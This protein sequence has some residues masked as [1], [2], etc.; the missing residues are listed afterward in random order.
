SKQSS[1]SGRED[2]MSTCSQGPHR[3]QTL[4]RCW[5]E[6]NTGKH[7]PGGDSPRRNGTI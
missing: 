5:L 4:S 3:G 6:N 1:Y 7:G 2:K